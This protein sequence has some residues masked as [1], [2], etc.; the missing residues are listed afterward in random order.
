MISA[1]SAETLFL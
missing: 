1:W